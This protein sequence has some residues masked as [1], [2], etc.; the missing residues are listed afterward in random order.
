MSSLTAPSFMHEPQPRP[1]E[2]FGK[3]RGVLLVNLGTPDGTDYWSM[4]RY[5]REFLWDARVIE[6]PRLI[7]WFILHGIILTF[8]PSKSGQ[9]YARIWDKV[10]NQSPLRVITE[11]QTAKLQARLGPS[12]LVRHAMRYGQPGIQAQLAA[13]QKEGA[14]RITVL[15]LYPQYAAATTGTVLD[16]VARH[17]LKVRWQ[18]SISTVPP[19]YD[20][21]AYIAALAASV[22]A[23][24]ASLPEAPDVLVASFHGLPLQY[25]QKGDVYYCHSHKTA[26]LLAEALGMTFCRTLAEISNPVGTTTQATRAKNIQAKAQPTKLLLTFQSRFG[27]QIWLQPYTDHTL[28]ALAQ[29]GHHKVSV[30][31]PG[32]AADCVETLEEI[33]LEGREAFLHAGGTQ[34]AVVPCL[35]DG[36]EGMDVIQALLK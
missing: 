32:F 8:R 12:V 25:C 28:E 24:L 35:N 18:P 6:V 23:H 33:A 13:M 19:Y 31:C 9:A 22:R 20:H 17:L 5:L 29:A 36:E 27:K 26:R 7:W 2:D 14:G 4:R 10:H 16:E 1:P 30:I 34:F 21:P 15:P 11:A 3:R